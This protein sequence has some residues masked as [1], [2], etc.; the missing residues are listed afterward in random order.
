MSRRKRLVSQNRQYDFLDDLVESVADPTAGGE[1]GIAGEP[2]TNGKG[3]RRENG[4]KASP[5]L[6]PNAS[7]PPTSAAAAAAAAVASSV[8]SGARAPAMSSV[9][10][11]SGTVGMGPITTSQST[12]YGSGK[13]PSNA[14]VILNSPTAPAMGVSGVKPA[15]KSEHDFDNYD[16]DDDDDEDY[17]A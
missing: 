10:V 15:A 3:K 16:D 14:S 2:K 13:G 8:D 17:D 4:G 1:S 12:A 5:A 7:T 6:K 9:G 11:I